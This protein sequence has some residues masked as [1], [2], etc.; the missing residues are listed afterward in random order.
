LNTESYIARILSTL[1][2]RRY[3]IGINGQVSALS[4]FPDQVTLAELAQAIGDLRCHFAN[5]S[6]VVFS[7]PVVVLGR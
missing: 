1:N 7:P 3:V 4:Q 6:G 5:V 2:V